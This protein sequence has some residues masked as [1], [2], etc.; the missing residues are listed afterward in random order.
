[1]N[2]AEIIQRLHDSEINGSV[3]W[4]FDGEWRWRI[5]DNLN[6]WRLEGKASMAESA[7]HD[8]AENAFAEFP[9]SEFATWWATVR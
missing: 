9:R 5:G 4:F 8:L 6:G 2:A 3:D 7:L 1:M